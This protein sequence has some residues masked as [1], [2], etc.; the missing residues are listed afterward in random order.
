MV[1]GNRPLHDAEQGLA[2][3]AVGLVLAAR[4][5]ADRDPGSCRQALYCFDE[6]AALDVAQEGD[7]VPGDLTPEAVVEAFFGVDRERCRLLGMK[8]AQADIAPPNP[9]ERRV[10]TYQGEDVGC[11][12]DRSHVVV[13]NRHHLDGTACVRGRA[14]GSRFG[15]PEPISCYEEA[16]FAFSASIAS[17]AWAAASRATGTRNGEQLT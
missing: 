7:R 5:V 3:F 10:L 1:E 14:Q 9:L 8:R 4:V 6:V 13:G 2:P 11:G 12:A 17:T 15:W 16:C